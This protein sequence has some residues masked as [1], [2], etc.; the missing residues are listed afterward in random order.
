L[1]GAI[2]GDIIGS[3][4]EFNNYRKKDFELFTDDCAVTDD[5]IMTIAVAK[6]IMETEKLIDSSSSSTDSNLLNNDYFSLLERMSIKYM[7][8]IGRRYPD[9]G[10]GGMFLRWIFSDHPQPYNSFGN[11]AAMRI[12]TVGFF[13]QKRR[14]GFQAF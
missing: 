9:S 11:G 10:Y 3:R 12:S 7:Q 13:C 4:F 14:R 1:F 5:T 6:A 8:E 2:I